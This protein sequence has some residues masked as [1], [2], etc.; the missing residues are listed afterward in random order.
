MSLY[1]ALSIGVAGLNA[2]SQALSATSSNIANINTVGY[3]DATAS[4]SSFLDATDG[5]GSNASAGVTADIGQDVTAQGL[6][7]TTSSPTDLSISG[8]GFFV[9]NT[10]TSSTATQEYT[11]AGSFTP[12]SSGNLENS[13]GLYLMGYKLDSAGNPP[14]DTSDLRLINV[15]SLSGTASPTTTISMQAN[16]QSSSTVDSSY[17]AGDM[18]AGN[19]TPDFTH[20]VDVYDTQGGQQPITFSFVK[21]A[22]N[23]WAYEASY[24]G[25]STNLSSANPIAEGT[26]SFNADGTLA[27]VNGASP[28]SGNISLTIPWNSTTSGLQPQTIA[29]SLG[30]VGSSSGMTQDDTASTFTGANVDGSAYGSVTGVTVG[31]DGTVTAQ[32]SN[33]LSQAVYKIPIATFTNEDGLGQV[34]GNAYV[35]TQNSG[36]ANINMA[37]AGPAGGIQSNSLEGSTVDLATEFTNLITTQRA[38]SASAQIIQTAN[39]MLQVLEQLPSAS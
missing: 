26:M 17:T 29:V 25:A 39:Q 28:A 16:L 24:A 10:N 27:N 19:V 15:D 3:K 6:P 23:T 1:G 5:T 22:A 13:A 11:R 32:F 33:G 37:D 36:T 4:F 7:T 38:Y 9:V 8:N 34:S 14:A 30:T 35:A 12:D 2:N 31:K 21:T 18:T 20:T